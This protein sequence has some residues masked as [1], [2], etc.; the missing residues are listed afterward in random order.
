MT[1]VKQQV[2]EW[3]PQ[4]FLDNIKPDLDSNAE[5]IMEWHVVKASM[6]TTINYLRNKG[7]K[8]EW[9]EKREDVFDIK[10]TKQ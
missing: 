1:E 6:I 9:I 3:L 10:I 7:Y 4:R 5:V 2:P 8:C